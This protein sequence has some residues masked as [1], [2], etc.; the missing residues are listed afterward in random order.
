MNCGAH[1]GTVVTLVS[2][3]KMA[4]FRGWVVILDDRTLSFQPGFDAEAEA[5]RFKDLRSRVNSDSAPAHS[6]ALPSTGTVR[7]P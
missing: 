4:F 2:V 3:L 1:I 7:R 6:I 5:A